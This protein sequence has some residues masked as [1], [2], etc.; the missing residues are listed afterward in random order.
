M[1]LSVSN[2][3]NYL[4]GAF[5]F[6]VKPYSMHALSEQLR[7]TRSMVGGETRIKNVPVDR[8][9]GRQTH[10]SYCFQER[11]S[12]APVSDSK[13]VVASAEK[14]RVNWRNNQ[15]H[16]KRVQVERVFG[17]AWD[18]IFTPVA[19]RKMALRHS[20]HAHPLSS[21]TYNDHGFLFQEISSEPFVRRVPFFKICVFSGKSVD[22]K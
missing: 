10:K 9:L 4:V 8:R 7:Q 22:V 6:T 3:S 1:S 20:G 13:M 18:L 21:V 17:A 15:A 19:W 2:K 5:N 16:E 14:V 12:S 11:K